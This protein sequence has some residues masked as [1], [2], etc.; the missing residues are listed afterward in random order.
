MALKK[1]ADACKA[2]AEFDKRYPKAAPAVKGRAQA[3]KTQAKCS[4]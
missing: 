1:P 2:L 4:A 3:A